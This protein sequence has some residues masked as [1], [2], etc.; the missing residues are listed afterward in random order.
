MVQWSGLSFIPV[1]HSHAL[2][3]DASS[4]GWGGW[5]RRVGPRVML[6]TILTVLMYVGKFDSPTVPSPHRLPVG[7]RLEHFTEAWTSLPGATQWHRQVMQGIPL[8]FQDDQRPP[9]N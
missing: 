2:T 9:E 3:T 4:H 5:W 8:V 7:G 1:Q 6:G